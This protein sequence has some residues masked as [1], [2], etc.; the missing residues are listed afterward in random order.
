LILRSKDV[1]HSLF[2]PVLRFKQDA[3]PGMAINMHFTARQTGRYEIACTELCGLGHY[4]MRT[5]VDILSQEDFDKWL[6]TEAANR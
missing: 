2:I 6:A 5:F 3:V 4:R 1:I